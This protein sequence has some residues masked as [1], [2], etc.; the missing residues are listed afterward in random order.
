VGVDDKPVMEFRTAA[1]WL[2]WLETADAP[3]GVRL[4]LR[5]KGSAV[6]VLTY[7]EALDVA[8]C[9][10][11]IDGQVKSFDAD[12]FLTVFTPR[13]RNSRWDAAYRQADREVPVDLQAA[14]DSNAAAAAAFAELSAQNR[15]AIVFRLN[16]VKRAETRQR[17]LNE[18]I[19]MLERGETLHPR[20][21]PS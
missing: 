16:A 17:K 11:W 21:R 15:F 13:R 14:L 19:A 18:F 9:F 6:A 3:G 5:K 2:S 4:R 12:S 1:D 10:G 7:A 8:L 20:K